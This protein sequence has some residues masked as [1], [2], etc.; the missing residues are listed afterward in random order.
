MSFQIQISKVIVEEERL[1]NMSNPAK[2][3]LTV[4]CHW[5]KPV[6]DQILRQNDTATTKVAEVYGVLADGGPVGH[7]RS[8]DAVVNVARQEAIDFRNHLRDSGIRFT[9]LL[10]APFKFK[11]DANQLKDLNAY[12]GW[13]LGELK[14]DALTISSYE[15]MK[16]VRTIDRDISI[17]V[18]TIA[19]VKNVRD[20]QNYMDARPD[21]VVPHHDVGKNWKDLAELTS[22]GKTNGIKT[23]LLVTE[24]CLYQ[25]PSRV[26]H[27]EHLARGMADSPF[28]LVCNARKFINPSEFL[29]AGGV[30]RPEDQSMF[31]ELGVNCLKISG[32]SKP[33]EWLPETVG[34]YQ[35]GSYDGNLIRLLGI[36]P[37]LRA[38]EWF[39]IDN[40]ALY[41][42]MSDFPSNHSDEKRRKYCEQ[43]A[44]KLHSEGKLIVKD[45][46]KY[47]EVEGNLRLQEGGNC[48]APIIRREI[49]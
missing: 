44:L 49:G 11:D 3:E 47:D 35:R 36:D 42:F 12:L 30:I 7:G 2:T 46:S 1:N 22:F 43:W 33:A 5:N 48:I 4:P 32:R 8:S 39:Y 20:L 34:A 9:Y 16:H 10:N 45:G 25:C 18:S 38:E 13:V 6:M 29:L 37:S 15:L 27:Y 28:H 40:K 26:A 17:H 14:P 41:G 24:S 23:E 31:K 19:G 21:G